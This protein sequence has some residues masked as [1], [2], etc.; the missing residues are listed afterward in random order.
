[1]SKDSLGDRIKDYEGRTQ[2]LLPRKTYSVIRLDGKAFHTYTKGL[3]RP[4]DLDLMSDMDETAKYLCENIAGT[5]LAYTQSDEITLILADFKE[6]SYKTQAWFDGNLQKCVS[7][8][9]SLATAKFN[10]LRTCRKM[11]AIGLDLYALNKKDYPPKLA[12]FDSRIFTISDPWEI[13]NIL[14]WR[15][16]DCVR[17]SVQMAAQSMF[18]HKELQ[19][20]NV[21]QLQEKMWAE[22]QVNWNDYPTGFKNGRVVTKEAISE[23]R[24]GW[25]IQPAPIFSKEPEFV[26]SRL[27]YYYNPKLN[28]NQSSD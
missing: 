15:N 2:V 7:I 28:D 26:L 5:I 23:N 4:Y 11:T 14:V 9:A 8:S 18:S 16:Q 6:G 25:V 10:Q 21:T 17:N 13:Q 1:M 27:P 3:N 22:K 20:V 19:G 24:T 12:C